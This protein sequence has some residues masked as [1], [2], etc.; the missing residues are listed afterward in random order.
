MGAAFPVCYGRI[1]RHS[2]NATNLI[3]SDCERH[4]SLTSGTDDIHVNRPRS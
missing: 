1:V 4:G 3:I 2:K